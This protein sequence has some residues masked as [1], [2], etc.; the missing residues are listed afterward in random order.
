M[1][2]GMDGEI[3]CWIGR[4]GAASAEHVAERFGIDRSIAREWLASLGQEGML[5]L[6][7]S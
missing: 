6:F 2:T 3:V 7:G 5:E 1:R 4:F